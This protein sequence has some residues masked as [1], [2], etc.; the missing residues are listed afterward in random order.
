MRTILDL[1]IEDGELTAHFEIQGYPISLKGSFEG[2]TYTGITSFDGGEFPMIA[3]KK[4][5]EEK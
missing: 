2:D 1:V 5:T 3:T 4:Q